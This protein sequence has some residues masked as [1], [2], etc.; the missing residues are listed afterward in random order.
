MELLLLIDFLVADPFVVVFDP[1][2]LVLGVPMME[3]LRLSCS[4][5]NTLTGD[6]VDDEKMDSR[7]SQL[8]MRFHDEELSGP[9]FYRNQSD[10]LTSV[11][12]SHPHLPS[13]WNDPDSRIF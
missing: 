13:L 4:R 11:L 12:P 8:K 2:R 9:Y 5:M 6:F 1:E 10:H 3:L 7:I